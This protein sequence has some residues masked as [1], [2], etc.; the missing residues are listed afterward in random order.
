MFPEIIMDA[1]S[2][3]AASGMRARMES[4]EMLANNLANVETGGFKADREFF[5]VYAGEEATADP[6]TGDV[7]VMPL[8]ETH[9]TDLSQ[10]NLL[11]TSNPLD[12]AIDG[13]GLFAI[14]T[15]EGLRY[16]RNGSF[17]IG[18]GG[19]LTTADGSTVRAQGGGAVQLQQG[20]PIDVLPDGTV[21]QGGQT[22]GQLDVAVFARGTLDK[23]GT[24]YFVPVGAA[25]AKPFMGAVVQ[26]KLEQSNVGAAESSVR[27]IAIMRQFEMLQKA[28]NI[29]NDLNRKA[30][31]E[32]ARVA[33]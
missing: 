7:P 8:I 13:D 16:T 33:S 25:K 20:L 12:L 14:Q 21:Q 11:N 24:N 28:M 2:T 27:L 15:K 26:G 23:I 6:L 1:I 29:G 30:I 5:S 19:V 17:R 9:W 31:E 22:V 3:S 18:S 4:L 10:G 32:V